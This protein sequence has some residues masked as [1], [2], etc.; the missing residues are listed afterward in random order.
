M[1]SLNRLQRVYT[2]DGIVAVMAM[3]AQQKARGEMSWVGEESWRELVTEAA[4]LL[5]VAGQEQIRVQVGDHAVLMAAE[6]DE[7]MALVF[8]KGHP[9]V[10]SVVRMVR[11]L[12]RHAR[13]A[14]VATPAPTPAA[15]PSVGA[16]A[17]PKSGTG[18]GGLF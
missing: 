17:E 14:N 3:D 16:A 13:K 9:V 1:L 2:H 7:V 5:K 11:Q 12:L 4:V 8:V 10:K 18:T 6:G 15:V